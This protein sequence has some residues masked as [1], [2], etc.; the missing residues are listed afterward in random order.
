MPPLNNFQRNCVATAIASIF[1]M[2]IAN[3]GRIGVSGKA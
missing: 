3:A 2:G 1:E